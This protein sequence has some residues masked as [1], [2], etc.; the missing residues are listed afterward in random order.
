M[1]SGRVDEVLVK[2]LLGNLTEEE[3]AR[4]E[5]QAF[6][7]PDYLGALEAAEA[8]LIDAYVRGELAQAD[9]RGFECRF[10]TSPQ[11]RSKVEFAR[12]LARVTA[13][14]APL[15]SATREPV[16]TWQALRDLIRGWNPA[17][18]FAGALAALV[19]IAGAS[20][21]VLENASMRSR[22]SAL[23]AQRRDLE[24]REQG[25]TRDL[26]QA[27]SR[28][29]SLAAQMQNR[30]SSEGPRAPL[31]ASLVLMAG[32]SRAETRVEQLALSPG[33]LIAHIEIQLEA[34]DD[35][36][37]FRADLHARS[38]REILVLSD[39][40]RR[41]AGGRYTVSIDVPASALGTGEYELALKG[42]PDGEGAQDVGYYYFHVQKQ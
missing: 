19:C 31:V 36:P 4:V 7:D 9:R 13:E 37:R 40:V 6:A 42:L 25:L 14:A 38:G 17:L 28:A 26:S 8:D 24:V 20:W 33:A 12:A 34:R 41:R 30:Q 1:R 3:Q 10:L 23:R 39:L 27:Q 21:L 2:Y 32:L 22:V 15:A 18:Q 16:S 35:F 11:R 5:D 29:D